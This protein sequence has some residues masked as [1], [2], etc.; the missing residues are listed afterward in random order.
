MNEH[1][2]IDGVVC[3]KCG[4]T[5][6]ETNWPRFVIAAGDRLY[7]IKCERPELRTAITPGGQPHPIG[8]DGTS[9]MLAKYIG[10]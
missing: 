10:G 5:I 2:G 9:S 7:H 8:G 6:G 1:T 3:Y 4:Q